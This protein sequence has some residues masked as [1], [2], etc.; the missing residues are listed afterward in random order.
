MS[1]QSDQIRCLQK[2]LDVLRND[3]AEAFAENERLRVQVHQIAQ[4]RDR[5]E[6]AEG[7]LRALNAEMIPLVKM[8]ASIPLWRDTYVDGPD[9]FVSELIDIAIYFTPDQIR[10]ARSILAKSETAP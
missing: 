9:R 6:A 5:A 2:A 7:H 4:Q 1:S 8:V 3:C 10:Q